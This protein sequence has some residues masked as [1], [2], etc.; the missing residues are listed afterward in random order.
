MTNLFKNNIF[1]ALTTITICLMQHIAG[2]DNKRCHK[3]DGNIFQALTTIIIYLM[4][5]YFRC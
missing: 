2:A 1:Q 3:I 4:A 5:T